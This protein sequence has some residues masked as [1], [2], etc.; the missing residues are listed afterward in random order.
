VLVQIKGIIIVL[1][2]THNLVSI[3]VVVKAAL[4]ASGRVS[5]VT[6]LEGN[7]S[8]G[9]FQDGSLSTLLSNALLIV[10]I[11]SFTVLTSVSKSF[12][13]SAKALSAHSIVHNLSANHDI[14]AIV[15]V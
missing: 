11:S 12:T 4:I 9:I 14:S 1:N 10:M 5:V 15:C 3:I 13:S 8:I 2:D 6:T 7:S